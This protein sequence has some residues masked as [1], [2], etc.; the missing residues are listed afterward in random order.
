M[1]AKAQFVTSTFAGLLSGLQADRFDIVLSGINDTLE[2]EKQVDFVDYMKSGSN[3]LIQ[4]ANPKNI[5]G[6]DDLCGTTVGETIGTDY[7]DQVKAI[8]TSKC[9]SAGKP[10]I[11]IQTFSSSLQ[12]VQ[13]LSTHRIDATL[14]NDI[15]N[16]QFVKQ[17]NGALKAVG[18]SVNPAPLGIAVSKKNA[19]LKAAIQSALDGLISSGKYLAIL[20]SWGIQGDAVTTVTVNGATS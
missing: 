9:T 20:K 7:G 6:V 10:A 19:D 8:S 1:G 11:K 18:E 15:S 16:A 5:N 12:V 17:S 3:L 14:A 13:A 2:R 4:A